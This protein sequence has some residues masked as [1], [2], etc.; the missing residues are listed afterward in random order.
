M[1]DGTGHQVCGKGHLT[2][3]VWNVAQVTVGP[4]W[5]TIADTTEQFVLPLA[6][7]IGI[8]KVVE[9]RLHFRLGGLEQSGSAT[10]REDANFIVYVGRLRVPEDGI[11]AQSL[12]V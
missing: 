9:G 4:R 6:F 1:T 7:V 10:G 5:S 12:L 11:T 3:L 8:L 2:F